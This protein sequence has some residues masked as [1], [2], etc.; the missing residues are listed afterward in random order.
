MDSGADVHAP[1]LSQIRKFTEQ[2][3]GIAH[4][5]DDLLADA[6]GRAA[7]SLDLPLIAFLLRP[8]QQTAAL[9]VLVDQVDHVFAELFQ[10]PQ[11]IVQPFISRYFRCGKLCRSQPHGAGV[12]RR[13]GGSTAQV[14]LA[15]RLGQE[16]GQLLRVLFPVDLNDKFFFHG[17]TSFN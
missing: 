2:I 8:S 12:S 7:G 4:L 15:L 14:K 3:Q 11:N 1:L 5:V 13:E 10:I 6:A 16:F 17:R 9:H